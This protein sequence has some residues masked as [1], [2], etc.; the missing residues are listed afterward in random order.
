MS[1]ARRR[2][3]AR[4]DRGQQRA[5]A[6]EIRIAPDRRREVA[7]ARRAQPEVAEVAR[8]VVR[9]LERPQDER[10]EPRAVPRRRSVDGLGHDELTRLLRRQVIGR[11]R[12]RDVQRHELGQQPLDARRVRRLVDAVQRRPACAHSSS[13]ATASLAAIIRNSISLCDSVC[14]DGSR[15]STCPSREKP[16]SGS[17]DSTASAPRRSRAP[18]SASATRRAA[19]SGVAHGSSRALA[20]REDPVHARVVEPLVGADHRAV[21]RACDG[22]SRPRTP[23]RPSRPAGPGAAPASTRGSTAPR[24]ASA[25]P[26]RGRRRSSRAGTP[27]GRAPSRLDERRRRRRCGPRPGSRRRRAPRP[28]SRRR[29]PS[30]S[31]GRS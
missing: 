10:R 5:V 8:R 3:L 24:A 31:A 26:G 25:R 27:R 6:H 4:A 12:R 13:P 16:N 19:A 28:R 21:E 22:P 11:R 18:A 30:R 15:L 14:S 1:E 23:S 2:V 29:S 17:T 7:V 9:L 20:P